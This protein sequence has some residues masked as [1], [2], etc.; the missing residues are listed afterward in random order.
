M[1]ITTGTNTPLT[2]SARRA[3]GAFVALASSTSW[4]IFDRLV[5]APTRVAR[6]SNEPVRLMVA[7]NTVSPAVFSCGM[8][9]PVRALSSTA[10]DPSTTMPSTGMDSPGLTRSICPIWTSE[11]S[12]VVSLPSGPTRCASLGARS[13]SPSMALPV[14]DLLRHSRY[15]PTVTSVRIVPALSKYRLSMAVIMAMCTSAR[16]S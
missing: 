16:A 9:S 13:I 10:E 7:A 5:S 12:T 15:L 11:A 6:S 8:D 4:M 2:L 3:M 1:P 14:F